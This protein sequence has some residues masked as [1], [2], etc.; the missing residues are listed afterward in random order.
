MKGWF[1]NEPTGNAR[2]VPG[3]FVFM[4]I[5]LNDGG[6]GTTVAQRLTTA[7]SVRVVRL[8]P[9]AGD[10][11]GT[12]LRCASA[13]SPR[14]FVFAYDNTAGSGRPISGSFIES[15]GTA[16]TTANSYAAFY[17]NNVNGID[18]AFGIVVPNALPNGIRRFERRSLATG[19]V[20]AS[21]T[22]ADGVWPS[23]ANTINPSG[24][25]T[26]I[27]LTGADVSLSTGV[28]G[29]EDVPVQ[30]TLLQNYPNPFNPTT[31]IS[32]SV[33]TN[34]VA[35]LSIYNLLGQLVASPFK[36]LVTP[37]REYAVMFDAT[38]L[39]SGIY[40]YRLSSGDRTVTKSMVLM[41]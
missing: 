7:D 39:P 26:E 27:V 18:G 19:A 13:A 1:I 33:E 23:G 9:A 36:E 30:F 29:R 41:K 8:H 14:D 28:L 15:D 10:T 20:V 31:T 24:G 40:F 38:Q 5:M 35:T 2:F 32:F 11:T 12:G 6:T 16:N 34:G 22:D 3:R 37:G 21:A 4:R 25:T 17:A